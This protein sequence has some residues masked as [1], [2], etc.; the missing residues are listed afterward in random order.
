G[1]AFRV[2]DLHLRPVA[3]KRQPLAR[4]C[5]RAFGQIQSRQP[6]RPRLCPLEMVGAHT[7]SN[8]ENVATRP[9]LEAREVE[10]VW[11]ECV[12]G[13]RRRLVEFASR[14]LGVDLAAGRLFPEVRDRAFCVDWL[15]G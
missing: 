14:A 5:D 3:G 6:A 12:T 10:D 1:K 2:A 11:L 13:A 8:L 4:H 9:R 15:A 7:D